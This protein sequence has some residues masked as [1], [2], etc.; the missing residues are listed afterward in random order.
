M[1][2]CCESYISVYVGTNNIT[3]W[4]HFC[5]GTQSFIYNI[6]MTFL[7]QYGDLLKDM[8]SFKQVFNSRSNSV[9]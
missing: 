1:D 2:Q 9:L 7:Y 5:R 8:K 3:Y 6:Y 4:L